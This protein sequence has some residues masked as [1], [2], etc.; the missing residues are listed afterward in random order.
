MGTSDEG[1]TIGIPAGQ[2]WLAV[3][4]VGG[5]SGFGSWVGVSSVDSQ[6]SERLARV[7][8]ALLTLET[9]SRDTRDAV[10][11]IKDVSA[12]QDARI[13]AIEWRLGLC[14]EQVRRRSEAGS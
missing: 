12:G 2:F 11:S 5:L 10:S 8:Q 4:A 9:I 3:A 6:P 7:E 13:R 14:E 1:A